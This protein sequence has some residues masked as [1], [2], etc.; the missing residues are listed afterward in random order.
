VHDKPVDSL[1]A[2]DN[3]TQETLCSGDTSVQATPPRRSEL[4]PP[5]SRAGEYVIDA[6]IGRGGMGAVYAARQPVIGKR[7][8]VKVLSAELS[9]ATLVQRFVDEARAVNTIGHPNIVDIFAFGQLSDGRHYHVMELLR[10]QSLR[11]RMTA[12][13]LSALEIERYL[14]QLCAA[15]QAAHDAGIVHR[16]LKPENVWISQSP[17]A[18]AQLKLL[19]FGVAKFFERP[20]GRRESLTAAGSVLGTPAYM[21]PEQCSGAR[22]DARTDIYALGVMLYEIYMGKLP[23][24]G[25]GPQLLVQHATQLPPPATL[26]PAAVAALIAE[27]LAKERAQ[28]PAEAAELLERLHSAAG[29]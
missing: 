25:T 20:E 5:G 4:L 1:P 9:D 14:T 13:A 6:L 26:A 18:Q 22:L 3:A 15:L 19:D 28:R 11:E 2:P 10:G 29:W 17:H 7:V 23:F 24:E 16:D 12:G 27:C 8:A 21:S